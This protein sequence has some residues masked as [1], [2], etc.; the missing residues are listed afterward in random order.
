MD[1][2]IDKLTELAVSQKEILVRLDT[3][4]KILDKHAELLEKHNEVLLR[5]TITVEEHHRRSVLLEE[6]HE[7]LRKDLDDV[8]EHVKGVEVAGKLIRWIGFA[9]SAAIAVYSL[10]QIFAKH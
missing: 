6:A 1:P 7:V 2:I 10:F 4:Q 5:N 8:Q 3:A 9:A